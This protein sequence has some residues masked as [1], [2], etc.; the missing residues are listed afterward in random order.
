MRVGLAL[1]GGAF[2]LAVVA[3]AAAQD[4]RA[5]LQAYP[6]G[7]RGLNTP[8]SAA[9]QMALHIEAACTDCDPT[10]VV[11]TFA[12]YASLRFRS[13]AMAFGTAAQF[14]QAMLA[15][16]QRRFGFLRDL[17]DSEQR[18]S[19]GCRF[20]GQVEGLAGIASLDMIVT[21]VRGECNAAPGKLRASY[22]SGFDGLCLYRVR[23]K[24]PGWEPLPSG[25]QHRVVRFLEQIRFGP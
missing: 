21:T 15:D 23:V 25:T 17:I 10:V 1:F 14:A 11:E 5:A 9:A 6:A 12:G 4:C 7:W 8:S 20:E 16:P 19:P 18:L 3:S 13:Q 2:G 24:W 22:F